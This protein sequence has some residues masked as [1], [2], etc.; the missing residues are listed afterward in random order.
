MRL[1]PLPPSLFRVNLIHM[2]IG[3]ATADAPG[4][5]TGLDFVPALNGGDIDAATACFARDGCLITPDATAVHGRDRIRQLLVQLVASRTEVEVE[6]STVVGAGEV[7]LANERWRVRSGSPDGAPRIERT[8]N[9]ILVLR[10][11]EAEWKL[12]I[13]APW[14]WGRHRP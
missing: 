12:A 2:K 9:P 10:E 5:R 4:A 3:D 7:I 14:G 1:D 6:L 11:I 8:L 13:A